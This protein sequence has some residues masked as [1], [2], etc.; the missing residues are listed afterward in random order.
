MSTMMRL[1][2]PEEDSPEAAEGAKAHEV[3]WDMFA[4]K[5]PI[6]ATQEMIEGA[7]LLIDTV[8]GR[9]GEVH[10]NIE[11]PVSIPTL[12]GQYGTPDLWAYTQSTLII[13][14]YKFGFKHVE[15]F[16]NDQG[17]LY[18]DGILNEIADRLGVGYGA[19]DQVTKVEFWIVQPR[20]FYKGM[21]V[22]TW[23]FRASDIRGHLNVLRDRADRILSGEMEAAVNKN[24]EYCPGRHACDAL[25]LSAYN[26]AAI[27]STA[28]P[29]DMSP[30]SMSREL[31]TLEYAAKALDARIDGLQE[32][33]IY[34][35]KSGAQVPFH[36]L[37][38]GYGNRKWTLDDETLISLGVPSVTKVVT[39]AQAE[40]E[41]LDVSAFSERPIGKLSLQPEDPVNVRKVFSNGN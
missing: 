15:E 37:N 28:L 14:D 39:P 17:M 3:A 40:K 20:C 21:P 9:I 12:Q 1:M 25:Q 11:Q 18:A 33:L 35:I 29:L 24:C 10:P 38:Q 5:Q 31:R 36:S 13:F 41:G 34:H 23:K 2:Y 26:A 7:Q 30:Q 16:E 22:R 27:P 19:L 4:G 32:S 8:R 6:D